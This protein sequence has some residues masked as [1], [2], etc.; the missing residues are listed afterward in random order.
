MREDAEEPQSE[1]E[2]IRMTY[3]MVK[4]LKECKDDHEKRIRDL[5]GSFWKMIGLAGMIGFVS[6]WFG[7]TFGSS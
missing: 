1:G 3:R 6:G 7:K 4:D 2:L 5:E